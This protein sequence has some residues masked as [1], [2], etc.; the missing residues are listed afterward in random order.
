[1]EVTG[2]LLAAI[3]GLGIGLYSAVGPF[4]PTPPEIEAQDASDGSS[5]IL[6][7]KVS[8][9]NRIFPVKDVSLSC[10][11]NL[12]LVMDAD[13]KMILDRDS[14]LQGGTATLGAGVNY[15]CDAEMLKIRPDGSLLMGF[16]S[17][18][19]MATK[20]GIFR[21]PLTVLKLCVAVM[22][23]YLD[24]RGVWRQLPNVMF[25]WPAAPGSHQWIK[26]PIVFETDSNRWVPS[27]AT[28][29]AAYGLRRLF[30]VLPDGSR[31]LDPK[32]L[33]CDWPKE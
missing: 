13:H 14:M 27:D 11:N 28:W 3:L 5:A 12:I 33:I 17:G 10:Y 30:D 9:K 4:W 23:T 2:T 22:G 18:T 16:E 7:F 31:K 25:Q 32:A 1:M 29:G 19:N 24:W 8:S 26:G 6:P 21:G 15:F 20:P